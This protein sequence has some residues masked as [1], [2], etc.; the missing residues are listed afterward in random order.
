MPRNIYINDDPTKPATSIYVKDGGSW[1]TVQEVWVKESG[2]WVQ[3]WPSNQAAWDIT[4]AEFS[5]TKDLSAWDLQPTGINFSSDGLKLYVCGIANDAI[6]QYT[7]STAYDITTAT[8]YGATNPTY[9]TATN[10]I[11]VFFDTTG[12]KMYVNYWSGTPVFIQWSLGTA[13]DITSSRSYVASKTPTGT[14]DGMI[15]GPS[16]NYLYGT[17]SSSS[18]TYYRYDFGTAY[19]VSTLGT[20]A[21]ASK[22]VSN[23]GYP[24]GFFIKPDGTRLYAAGSVCTGT[25]AG[26]VQEYSMSPAWDITTLALTGNTFTAALNQIVYGLWFSPD[27]KKMYMTSTGSHSIEQYTLAD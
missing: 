8:Y 25:T 19:S 18:N 14:N 24:I 27:G 1:R 23:S 20:T 3:T 9:S 21:T 16:G 12:T 5:G 2:S 15:L 4:G 26:Y 11:N 7:L 17:N 10:P 22:T 13:W 6:Y